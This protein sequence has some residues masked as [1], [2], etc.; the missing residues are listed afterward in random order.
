MASAGEQRGG[1]RHAAD[2]P[3]SALRRTPARLHRHGQSPTPGSKSTIVS[4]TQL[5]KS[6]IIRASMYQHHR[7]HLLPDPTNDSGAERGIG[8]DEDRASVGNQTKRAVA[9]GPAADPW[10]QQM[11]RSER[12]SNCNT[13]CRPHQVVPPPCKFAIAPNNSGARMMPAM[14]DSGRGTDRPATLPRAIDV[15]AIEDCTVEGRAQTNNTPSQKS[16]RRQQMGESQARLRPSNGNST[17]VVAPMARA[18]ANG[19]CHS[20]SHP[21]TSGTLQKEQGGDREDAGHETDGIRL[22]KA[23]GGC[24]ADT[25]P[26]PEKAIHGQASDARVAQQPNNRSHHTA[27]SRYHHPGRVRNGSMMPDPPSA[28]PKMD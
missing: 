5:S 12:R 15:R 25:K 1:D 22:G 10:P 2:D 8:D 19:S 17:K 13:T 23:G 11:A 20:R 28:L 26:T 24:Q 18:G 4:S 16:G 9:L 21:A 14:F 27:P 6:A 7:R 3:I